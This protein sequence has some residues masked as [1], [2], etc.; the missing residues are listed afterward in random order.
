[1]SGERGYGKNSSAASLSGGSS[2]S[3]AAVRSVS[4][5]AASTLPRWFLPSRTLPSTRRSR[6]ILRPKLQTTP[7]L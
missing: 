4:I 1:R 5:A 3:P 6:L 2:N 7:S